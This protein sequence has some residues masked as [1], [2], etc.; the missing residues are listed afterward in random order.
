VQEA[1]VSH[2]FSSVYDDRRTDFLRVA[3]LSGI[4]QHNRRSG[5]SCGSKAYMVPATENKP[6]M[7]VLHAR[8]DVLQMSQGYEDMHVFGIIRSIV[9]S[10]DI[11]VSN[12]HYLLITTQ[13]D[14]GMS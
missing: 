9:L 2:S 14:N 10:S 11:Q 4:A 13:T 12:A 5:F 3:G 8:H 1:I 7:A 6:V